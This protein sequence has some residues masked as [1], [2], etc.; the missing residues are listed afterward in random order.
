MGRKQRDAI[1]PS[2]GR[3]LDVVLTHV[4]KSNNFKTDKVLRGFTAEEIMCMDKK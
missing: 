2:L 1:N 3:I 4:T